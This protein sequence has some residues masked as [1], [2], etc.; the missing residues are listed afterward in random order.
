M[1]HLLPPNHFVPRITPPTSAIIDS[2]QNNP[3]NAIATHERSEGRS[4]LC[5]TAANMIKVVPGISGTITPAIPINIRIR[6][7]DQMMASGIETL[8][9]AVH[10]GGA[11]FDHV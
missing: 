1:P 7:T 6:V 5:S 3:M 8:L 2:T 11:D 4:T 10:F 9:S